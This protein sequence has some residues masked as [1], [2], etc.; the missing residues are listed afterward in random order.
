MAAGMDPRLAG[1][2]DAVLRRHLLDT[3]RRL[4]RLRPLPRSHD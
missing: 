4:L 1:L 2:D 3:A